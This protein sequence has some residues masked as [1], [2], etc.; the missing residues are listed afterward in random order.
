MS[1]QVV[2][3]AIDLA[4]FNRI[5]TADVVRDLQSALVGNVETLRKYGVIAQ[6]A[7]IKQK[8]LELGF[9]PKSLTAQQKALSILNITMEGTTDA[10]G[11]AV[12][13]A[14]SFANQ[15][16]ALQSEL[17]SV[18]TELGKSLLEPGK[19]VIATI[20]GILPELKDSGPA[21]EGM[22]KGFVES[23]KGA[24]AF[25][26]AVKPLVGPLNS[27]REAYIAIYGTVGS[28][29]INAIDSASRAL[30]GGSFMDVSTVGGDVTRSGDDAVMHAMST[31]GTLEWKRLQEQKKMNLNIQRGA[32]LAQ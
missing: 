27:I 28:R 5:P 7:Q 15:L 10:Q 1:S 14:G 20:K 17:K 8:A 2:K 32:G 16:V 4:S 29:V 11:D 6:E 23:A 13:T 9:N 26:K 18:G 21:L 24:V 30:G 22:A 19:D 12:R 25:A 31:P 3:L